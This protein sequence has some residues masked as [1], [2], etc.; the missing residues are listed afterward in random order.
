MPITLGGKIVYID[1]MVAQ[2]PLDFNFF[3]GYDYMYSMKHVVSRLFQVMHFSHK[4]NIMT[5]YHLSFIN[6]CTKI[7]HPISLSA[8]NV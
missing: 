3:L 8:P 4:K 6:N 7:A 1:F 5:I 2:G